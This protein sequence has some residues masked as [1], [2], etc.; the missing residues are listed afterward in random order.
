MYDRARA[1]LGRWLALPD[2][3]PTLPASPGAR[4]VSFHPDT[5]YLRYLQLAYW[6]VAAP[7]ALLFLVV[8]ITP[9]LGRYP[10]AA[11]WLLPVVALLVLVLVVLHLAVRLRFEMTWYVMSDRSLRLRRGV[12]SI[13]EKT[14]TFENIQNVKVRQ[15]PVQR[16]FGISS[17]IVETAGARSRDGEGS[18]SSGS[19]AVIEGVA[20]PEEIREQVLLRVRRSRSSGLGDEEPA[21]PDAGAGW[22]REHLEVLQQIR[23]AARSLRVR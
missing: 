2:E 18:G 9:I 11:P 14:M 1:V 5:G 8:S 21:R 15:G 12:F 16:L 17:V 6:S 3:A 23:D 4:V 10:E 13:E 22:T 20:R 19:R 7:L